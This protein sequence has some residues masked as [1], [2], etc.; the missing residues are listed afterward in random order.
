MRSV[1]KSDYW[2][3]CL[4][5]IVLLYSITEPYLLNIAVVPIPLLAAAVLGEEGIVFQKG[6][7]RQILHTETGPLQAG[8]SDQQKKPVS[9][10]KN[11]IMNAILTVSTFIFPLITFPYISRVLLSAGTG[12]V[13]FARSIIAYFGMIAALGIPTYG[14]RACAKV[15]DDK[16]AL[17]KV[18]HELMLISMIMTFFSY[19]LLF[20]GIALIPR[21][22]EETR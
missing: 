3:V 18:V 17:T 19:A 8:S 5:G 10:K 1:K 22:R 11:F 7:L 6:W 9:V 4:L 20:A 16:E 14:I 21:L 2:T 15:R 12:R 13:S